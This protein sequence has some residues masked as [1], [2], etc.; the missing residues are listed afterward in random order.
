MRRRSLA[1][2]PV[3]ALAASALPA[4][5]Q[6]WPTRP[7]TLV[8]GFPPGTSVDILARWLAEQLARTLGQPVVVENRPGV[9]G[10]IAA[11]HVARSRPDG[12]T[13]LYTTS[14][15]HGA[16]PSLYRN[17][18]FDPVA[19]FAPVTKLVDQ[20]MLVLVRPDSPARTL[21]ELLDQA[22]RAPR[23]LFYGFGNTS[24]RIGAEVLRH[25]AG[26]SFERVPYPGNPRS[27]QDLIAGRLDFVFTDFTTG[28]DQVRQGALRAL[29]VTSAAPN[30]Q[31]PDVPSIAQQGFPG[32]DIVAWG[33]IV[34]P[35][36]TPA[37][38]VARLNAE[39]TR[40]LS[41]PEAAPLF[42]RLGLFAAPMSPSAFGAYIRAE[43]IRW[44][45]YV[46]IAGIEPQ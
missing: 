23:P 17:L 13:I 3:A 20:P 42:H 33:G 29:A 4:R 19:D 31:L 26:V 22:R 39:I 8:A 9:D 1:T 15:S 28:V 7:I 27:L 40:A 34:A 18:A 6:A 25:R 12:Y 2:W 24:T 38:I 46:T 5:A 16:S 14:S 36:A 44:R 10:G 43:I 45:D 35:A 37:D 21:A 30:A 32:Y 41:A 11:T